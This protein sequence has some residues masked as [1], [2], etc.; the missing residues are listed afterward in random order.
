MSKAA[1][2]FSI[3]AFV[4][5]VAVLCLLTVSCSTPPKPKI[6][7]FEFYSS[8]HSH[9]PN[10]P[11]QCKSMLDSYCSFLFSPQ[12]QG[13]VEL[14]RS[15]ASSSPMWVLQGETANE[16]PETTYR[17]S[18]AKLRNQEKLPADLVRVL[19][20][21]N[22]FEKL[23][24]MLKRPTRASMTLS[25]RLQSEQVRAE[26]SSI[27]S[28]AIDEVIL[29]RTER[30]FPG[31]HKT[32]DRLVPLEITLEKRRIYR[33]LVS[34]ISKALWHADE[35]WAKVEVSFTKMRNSYLKLIAKLDV[36]ENIRSEWQK[37]IQEVKLVMPG[38]LPAI[39]DEECSSTTINAYYYRY[40]N[41]LTVCAGDFNSEDIAQTLAHEMGHSLDI[42]R[43]QYLFEIH[44][45]FGKKLATLRENVCKPKKFN[46][47]DWQAYKNS[48]NDSLKSLDHYEPV[49]PE[50]QRC[51]KRRETSKSLT[52]EDV[53][54]FATS[55][56][57]DRLSQL[58]AGDRFLRITKSEIPMINGKNQSNPAYLNPC[59]YYMW[60]NGEEPV[61]DELTTMMY[62]T[63]EYRCSN[64]AGIEK[65]KGAIEVAK[66]MTT[67]V[68]RKTL[69]VEGEFSGRPRLGG[70]GF[71]SPPDERFADV[72]GSYALSELL[73][74][75]PS[76]V[77]RQ[78]KLLASSSWQ[79]EEPSLSSHY[80][81]E[82]AIQSEYEMDSHAEGTQREKELLSAPI[83]DVIGCQK[84]F[85]FKECLLPLKH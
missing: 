23:D 31:F 2:R 13:N 76:K 1:H 4:F 30:K 28:S 54:R 35:N 19:R 43:D 44:S 53:Q 73:A 14:S 68:F 81:E 8:D 64:L 47:T 66:A 11:P 77:E 26:L 71:A 84:D 29:I 69:M 22:Y 15:T 41:V 40:L 5:A 50:F 3:S 60:S 85:E 9:D 24:L 72:V 45:D 51:L 58:S 36:S 67:E 62:F 25:E 10:R 49:L 46:C 6:E 83:R 37:R 38:S 82:S 17:Y 21:H 78:N 16:I 52:P 20:R 63:A 33:E 57:T 75:L 27:W 7:N 39:S 12:A 70:E 42:E 65:F 48:F 79:C 80:P 55:L 56:T 18:L 34:N 61:D 59:S 74:D 32:P